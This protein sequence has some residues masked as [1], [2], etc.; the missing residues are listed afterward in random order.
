MCKQ[1]IQKTQMAIFTS[2][3]QDDQE[4]RAKRAMQD[5]EIQQIL[6]TP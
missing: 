3:N 6:Q 2:N 1:G 4:Q 5:P